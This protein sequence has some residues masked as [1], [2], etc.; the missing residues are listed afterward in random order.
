VDLNQL[1]FD[2]QVLLIK[3]GDARQGEARQCHEIYARALA[4]RIASIQDSKG[5]GAAAYWMA[6][7][8]RPGAALC[9][10]QTARGFAS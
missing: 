2:H 7:S 8:V 9:A 3:A 6:Q 5:A 1:Y 4:G 10:A